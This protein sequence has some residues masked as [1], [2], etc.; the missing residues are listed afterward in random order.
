MYDI[1]STV[2]IQHITR[3]YILLILLSVVVSM[4]ME[5]FLYYYANSGVLNVYCCY[6]MIMCKLCLIRVNKER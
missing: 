1:S 2:S 6:F 4:S 5:I 3:K